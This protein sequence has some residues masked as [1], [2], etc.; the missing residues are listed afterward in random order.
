MQRKPCIL[1][2]VAFLIPSDN[3]EYIQNNVY[4]VEYIC[5]YL[6]KNVYRIMIFKKNAK[7]LKHSF[8]QEI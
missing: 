6:Q 8:E 1:Y 5:I 4:T 7:K 3:E 2:A